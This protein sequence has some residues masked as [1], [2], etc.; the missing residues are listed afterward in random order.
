MK[1]IVKIIALTTISTILMS[2]GNSVEKKEPQSVSKETTW[3]TMQIHKQQISSQVQLPGVMQPFQFVQIYP[4]VNGFVKMVFVDRGSMVHLGQLLVTLEAPELEQQ[5][6]AA[7]LKYAQAN[8]TYLTSIDRYNRLVETSKTPGTIS[9]FDLTSASDK[10]QGDS[11]TVQGE[12]ANYKAQVSM[13]SYLTVSAPFDGIITE[14]NVHPGALV[15]PG[16]QSAKPMLILQQLSK[17]RLVVDVPEQYAS[18]VKDGDT[19]HFKSNALPGQDYIGVISRSAQSLNNNFRSETI[20]IDIENKKN[21]FKPGMYAEV[22]LP[23]SG[24]INAF[25]VPKTAV[26]T[27]TERKYVIIVSNSI[28]HWCDI[29]EGNQNNDSTEVFGN[30][31]DGDEIISN[32]SYQV[33]DGQ[34]VR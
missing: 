4:R 8:A 19:I 14:R 17:L 25:V 1:N 23:V 26:V 30:M 7:K 32:A 10:M 18:Q 31:K 22:T 3:K 34:V 15:G 6:A 13:K 20:E 2:C 9:P 29:S 16:A 11:A 12:Y 28:A 21:I 5:V 27:T 24:S 33:K